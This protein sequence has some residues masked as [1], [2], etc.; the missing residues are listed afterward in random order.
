MIGMRTR[1]S[2]G[3]AA[4]DQYQIFVA[5]HSR[6]GAPRRLVED[7]TIPGMNGTL[8]IDKG[9]YEDRQ[10]TV[11]CYARKDCWDSV[12]EFRQLLFRSVGYQRLFFSDDPEEFFL[13]KFRQAFD[14]SE[15]DR[16]HAA[17]N[18][19]F[20]CKPQRFLWSG[21]QIQEVT[22]DGLRLA[23]PTDQE[24]KPLIRAYGTDGVLSVGS[25]MI[26]LDAIDEY[27][28]LDCEL[29][30]AMKGSTNCNGNIRLGSW[31]VLGSGYTGITFGG[32]IT[33][34]EVTPRWWRL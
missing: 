29:Q 26:Y 10:L 6:F 14:V 20:T 17:F 30:E 24:A 4:S 9:S 18:L 2:Y 34:A 31:P 1:M 11:S 22:A 33:K 8:T 21:E 12:Q 28:D 25:C 16:V 5:D 23:N 27:V 3:G 13:A 15:S 32:N 19:T 7:V